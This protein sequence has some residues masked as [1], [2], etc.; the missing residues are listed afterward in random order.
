MKALVFMILTACGTEYKSEYHRRVD[1]D[2]NSPP[3]QVADSL[4]AAPE[5]TKRCDILRTEDDGMK[6]Y[7][8]RKGWTPLE[9]L[10]ECDTGEF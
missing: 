3:Q 8:T 10:V 1:I 2:E 7:C 4:E 5:C 9:S 6:Y